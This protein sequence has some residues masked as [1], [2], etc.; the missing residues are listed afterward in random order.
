[1]DWFK[2]KRTYLVIGAF[3]IL[4]V[5][6]LI[7]GVAVPE[8]VFAVLAALSLG[9]LRAGIAEL[10]GNKGWRTYTAVGATIGIAICQALN[11]VLPFEIIY[12][13][14]GALGITGVRKAVSTIP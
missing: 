6:V 9:F 11:V 4:A 12:T 13:V 10:S 2:G 1:M 8:Y 14:L 7:V 5:L 3:T